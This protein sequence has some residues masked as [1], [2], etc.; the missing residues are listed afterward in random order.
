MKMNSGMAIRIVLFMIDQMR[1]GISA[2]MSGPSASRPKNTA[3][4][5]K[6]NATGKPTSSNNSATANMMSPI[7][8]ACSSA[9]GRHA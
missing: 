3:T 1:C 2:K 7:M 8:V 6:V 4:P 9:S 5:P